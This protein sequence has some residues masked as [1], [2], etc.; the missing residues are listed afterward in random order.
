MN[1]KH[2]GSWQVPVLGTWLC[3]GIDEVDN[4]LATITIEPNNDVISWLGFDTE[5]DSHEYGYEIRNSKSL[6]LHVYTVYTGVCVCLIYV[7]W[8]LCNKCMYPCLLQRW[9]YHTN[10]IQYMYDITFDKYMMGLYT[11]SI[12]V[13]LTVSKFLLFGQ[14]GAVY[15]HWT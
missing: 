10:Y 13:L 5:S 3:W 14:A 7:W 12:Y 1:Q 11:A 2:M 15:L 9:E 6:P 4:E 8:T